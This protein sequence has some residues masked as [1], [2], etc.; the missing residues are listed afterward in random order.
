VK[1]AIALAVAGLI[2]AAA[3]LSMDMSGGPFHDVV[4][5]VRSVGHGDG[6]GGEGGDV[7]TVVLADG[8]V[9]QAAVL[10][11]GDAAAGQSVHVRVYHRFIAGGTTYEV[12]RT[13]VMKDAATK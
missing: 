13:S 2:L 11:P 12:L 5:V 7:A 1:A 3:V 8:K 4:G 10:H 6:K 9:I